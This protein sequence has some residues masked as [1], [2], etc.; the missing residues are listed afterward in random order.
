MSMRDEASETPAQEGQLERR[1]FLRNAAIAAWSSPVI[2]SVLA[3]RAAARHELAND[4]G[5]PCSPTTPAT[6]ACVSTCTTCCQT[7]TAGLGPPA[8]GTVTGKA[9]TCGIP[10]THNC[11]HN[12]EC[13][14]NNCV[15]ASGGMANGVCT[16]A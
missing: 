13:C 4:C 7:G 2:V 16:A 9:N 3:G 15:G 10:L 1:R 12:A 11:Q 14:S 5:D 6:A 8:H